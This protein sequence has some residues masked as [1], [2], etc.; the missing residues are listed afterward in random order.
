LPY[1]TEAELAETVPGYGKIVL[2]ETA[3]KA[4]RAVVRIGDGLTLR[5][6]TQPY[7]ETDTVDELDARVE[8]VED[9][10]LFDGENGDKTLTVSREAEAVLTISGAGTAAVNGTYTRTT[11]GAFS[12]GTHRWTNATSVS[13]SL[14]ITEPLPGEYEYE[15]QIVGSSTGTDYYESFGSGIPDSMSD[16]TWSVFVDGTLPVPTSTANEA[17]ET[18]LSADGLT[19]TGDL[20]A[21]SLSAENGVSTTNTWV[22]A[23]SVTNTQVIVLSKEQSKLLNLHKAAR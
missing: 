20:T 7:A 9:T 6:L 8:T 12:V 2:D 23:N 4:G 11:S 15:A 16:L 1:A 3:L 17:L 19:T 22:D 14:W 5:G 18:T 21:T 13:V 10:A